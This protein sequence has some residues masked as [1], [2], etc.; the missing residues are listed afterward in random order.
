MRKLF[1]FIIAIFCVTGI[2]AQAQA[3]AATS[4]KATKATHPAKTGVTYRSC[5]GC[6]QMVVIFPGK[7][8]MGSPDSEAG[9][10]DD[11]GP[12]HSV[13]ITAYSIGK[14]EVT[15]GQFAEFVKRTRYSTG[16]KC[17]TLEKGSY[18]EH[19]GNWR[20]PG[21][22]QSDLDPVV[23]I[24]WNDAQ[25]YVKWLSRRTGKHY[26]LPT[27]AEWEYAARGGSGTARYWGSNPDDAC[28]YANGAD[29]TA[30]EKIH[31]ATSWSVHQCTDGFA[32]T[33][34]VGHFKPNAF[35]LHDMLGNVWEW[36]GDIYHVNY[37]GAPTDGSAWLGSGDKRL[38]RGG[39]WN[40]S[41]SDLRAAVRY[42][43]DPGL[44][45]SSFGFRV[46]RSYK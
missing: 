46:V 7:F 1:G 35:G 10:G 32:Y 14:T 17:W 37:K 30:Q 13:K 27:E 9:R 34:P 5:R 3:Q 40:N 44:R 8:D 12:V 21:F 6:P 11:E 33:A 39:S 38:L 28:A 25:A 23:C 19:N 26:R 18:K 20:E 29:K 31:G 43:N 24:N 41:P 22:A 2:L 4:V 36:T 15:R 42:K 45:F 16:D